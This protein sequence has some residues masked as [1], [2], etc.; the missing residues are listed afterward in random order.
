MRFTELAELFLQARTAEGA[1]PNTLANYRNDFRKVV[2]YIG[3]VDP[4]KGKW[5]N[6]HTDGGITPIHMDRLFS[7]MLAEGRYSAGT[8]NITQTSLQALFKWSRIRGYLYPDQDPLGGRKALKRT[9]PP[10]NRLSLGQFQQLLDLDLHPRDR[11][12]IALG[13]FLLLRQSE[14]ASLRIGDVDLEMNTIRVTV[15]KSKLVDVMKV[16]LEMRPIL[17]DYL[18]YYTTERGVLDDNWYLVPAKHNSPWGQSPFLK[19]TKPTTRVADHVNRA[20][21]RIGFP[22]RDADGKSLREGMHTLRRSGALNLY[23]E[24]VNHGSVDEAL[25]IVQNMLHHASIRTT[26]HYL[27]MESANEARN[28]LLDEGLMYPSLSASNVVPLRGSHEQAM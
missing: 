10:R 21:D 3:D 27:G 25:R 23:Y 17:R 28:K 11:M 26:E 13:M 15:H 8:V 5:I 19:P 1:R 6:G 22:T 18:T 16:P 24:L 14:A 7:A 4:V 2:R 9:P 20:L 12:I